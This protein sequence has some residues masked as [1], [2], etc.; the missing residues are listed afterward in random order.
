MS[1]ERADL[2]SQIFKLPFIAHCPHTELKPPLVSCDQCDCA[3]GIDSDCDCDIC[4]DDSE[5]YHPHEPI[6]C[7][8][9]TQKDLN[10]IADHPAVVAMIEQEHMEL[11]RRYFVRDEV[12]R[13]KGKII[14][15]Y[16][17]KFGSE[18]AA[19]IIFDVVMRGTRIQ[20][21]HVTSGGLIKVH[22]GRGFDA[23]MCARKT[24]YNVAA[25]IIAERDALRAEV[26]TLRAEVETLRAENAAL[27]LQVEYQPGGAGYEA[28][29]VHFDSVIKQAESSS[30]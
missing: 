20:Y 22:Y 14:F 23:N 21:Y 15:G 19:E 29:R 30:N 8:D 7:P 17:D 3:D 24:A 18:Y 4:A 10:Y 6:R 25:E 2:Y 16:S 1:S 28:A 27:K 12:D 5:F 26:E 11:A 9:M 13:R